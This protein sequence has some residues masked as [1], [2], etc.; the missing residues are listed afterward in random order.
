M[1]IKGVAVM[2][3]KS[4][5]KI[6]FTYSTIFIALILCTI[7]VYPS[8]SYQIDKE[9]KPSNI[10]VVIDNNYPPYIFLDRRGELQGILIDLW[11]L[12][13][14]KTGVK[15]EI[16]GMDWAEA[17]K[18]MEA[19]E[20]DVI[21][22]VFFNERRAK[23]YDF[24]KPYANID[25][26]IF[27]RKEIQ[28]ISNVDS[29]QGFP[30]AVK[31]GDA[32]I[33]YLK[34]NNITTLVE[35]P[36]YE[37]IIMAAKEHKVNVAVIDNPPAFYFLY[38]MDIEDSFLHSP[39][40]YRGQFHRA[41]KKGNSSILRL[42]EHGFSLISEKEHK[43]IEQKWLGQRQSIMREHL[44]RILIGVGIFLSILLI[45]A[46]WNYMLRKK[47]LE[48][49]IM[50]E[51]EIDENRKKSEAL[52]VSEEKY[53][54]IFENSVEGIYRT[55]RDG[56]FITVNP[57]MVRIFGYT[58]RE[59]MIEG[60]KDIAED[61]YIYPEERKTLI[62]TLEYQG[63]VMGFEF[64]S[65]RR[66]GEVI[67]VS[68]NCRTVKDR[69]GNIIYYEGIV[70]D[71]T[72]RKKA[73][74]SLKD[75]MGK[76]QRSLNGTI[77]TLSTTVEVRDPYTAGHQRRVSMLARLIAQDLHLPRETIEAI[78]MA[79][80]IHDLGKISVPAEILTKPTKLMDLEV[81]LIMTHPQAGY[82]ILKDVDLLYPVA[83]I[84]LQHHERLDG[85]GY[86][87]GLKGNEILFESMIITVA[88]V[89]EAI[90]T[91]RPYRA[92]LGID[93]ALSEIEKNKGILY[94]ERVVDTCVRLFREKGFKF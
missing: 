63:V 59:E 40:L 57:A 4:I 58:S 42:V 5:L 56:R 35:Y 50:L 3:K 18:R 62:D 49:T 73:E 91:H 15:V 26:S 65:K 52:A 23:I 22:M 93:V 60:V 78:T 79:G 34:A 45:M 41:V 76:L 68:T 43:N 9:I 87:K 16:Y 28:G 24:T 21:D 7:W 86:P 10:K 31:S 89:V 33:D 70:E 51:R 12:W 36:S 90:S 83:D 72:A 1:V 94:D 92:A 46:F 6:P 55:T 25:V 69:D 66:D 54:S 85:S 82:D 27:F 64:R 75:Y 29:L 80:S 67:W 37:A 13:E 38:K 48:R 17:L 19:G 81:R 39:P 47:V 77:Q 20:F 30:V 88:D 61:L 71:I 53:R 8:H 11:R 2:V 32:I 74:L 14:E 44:Q 84:V